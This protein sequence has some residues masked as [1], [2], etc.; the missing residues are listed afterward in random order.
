MT[1]NFQVLQIQQQL[2][3]ARVQ[4][5]NAL[6]G[7]NKALAAYHAAIGDLLDVRNIKVEEEP[8]Q[9]PH[10]P[11]FSKLERYN[12]LRYDKSNGSEEKK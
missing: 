1:T 10:F 8:V 3:D 9:E 4:E 6:V 12:W 5:L 2:S 7:Y 11:F